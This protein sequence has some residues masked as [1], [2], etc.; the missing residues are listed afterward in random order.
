MSN[1]ITG[2]ASSLP[3]R[4]FISLITAAFAA[5]AIAA[6]AWG[7]AAED[8]LSPYSMSVL[9]ELNE[10]A[11]QAAKDATFI[12]THDNWP[13]PDPN[14]PEEI[15]VPVHEIEVTPDNPVN[16]TAFPVLYQQSGYKIYAPI[17]EGYRLVVP[18][19]SQIIE[20]DREG[21]ELVMIGEGRS[22]F[23]FDVSRYIAR[24][25]LTDERRDITIVVPRLAK[26]P[27]PE[28][29][30]IFYQAVR[31]PSGEVLFFDMTEDDELVFSLDEGQAPRA[32]RDGSGKYIVNHAGTYRMAEAGVYELITVKVPGVECE[33]IERFSVAPGEEHRSPVE[34]ES[35]T[36][37]PAAPSDRDP[38]MRTYKVTF[39]TAYKMGGSLCRKDESEVTVLEGKTIEVENPFGQDKLWEQER[40]SY[41]SVQEVT[42]EQDP[43][44]ADQ[45]FIAERR[46]AT[47]AVLPSSSERDRSIL[48]AG[49]TAGGEVRLNVPYGSCYYMGCTDFDFDGR[50]YQV[51]I[52]PAE[53]GTARAASQSRLLATGERDSIFLDPVGQD[54]SGYTLRVDFCANNREFDFLAVID[55]VLAFSDVEKRNEHIAAALDFRLTYVPIGGPDPG[56]EEPDPEEPDAQLGSYQVVHEYYARGADGKHSFEG[57]SVEAVEQVPVDATV[58]AGDV[59]RKTAFG[60]HEYALAG[61]TDAYGRAFPHGAASQTEYD[62]DGLVAK[63]IGRAADGSLFA[64]A[65]ESGLQG[66]SPSKDGTNLVIMRYAREVPG[67]PG[68]GTDPDPDPDPGTDPDPDPAPDPDPGADP[69]PSDPADDPTEDA[70]KEVRY[71]LVGIALAQTDDAATPVLASACAASALAAAVALALALRRR[72]RTR[73]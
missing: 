70:V 37:E 3:K 17:I 28:P 40:F 44:C 10:D 23:A 21:Y 54:E 60:E 13:E 53:S 36:I 32:G 19:S 55:D 50:E 51:T 65:P 25:E 26:R 52:A 24:T 16:V 33:V 42:S 71:P 34:A 58:S 22:V 9:L 59:E 56:P 38:V 29:G 6:V 20:S 30:Q 5:F 61:M 2:K 27:D 1:D 11:P 72:A 45:P 67:D 49:G 39:A 64:Y 57:N 14:L 18:E 47:K 8:R 62:A 66:I 63:G 7:L 43:T 15:E 46:R 12:V 4:A 35:V 73:S 31:T 68:P 69:D 41:Y 48:I